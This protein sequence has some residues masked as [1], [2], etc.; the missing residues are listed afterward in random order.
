MTHDVLVPSALLKGTIYE[1]SLRSSVRRAA[2]RKSRFDVGPLFVHT[3]YI[4][5]SG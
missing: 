5:Q 1:A 4:I 3:D 2:S